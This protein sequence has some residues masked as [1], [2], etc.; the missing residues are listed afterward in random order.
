MRALT[1]AY[2]S[3]REVRNLE[4]MDIEPGKRFNVIHGDNG[5]GKTNTLEAMYIVCT[6]RS[7]RATRSSDVIRRGATQ[8]S[9][10][11]T[12]REEDAGRE[13]SV[14]L[15]GNLRTLRIDGAKPRSSA[16][17]ASRTPV[18]VFSPASLALTMGSS[19]ERRALLDRV[20]LY[21]DASTLEEVTSYTHALRTR[22][23]VLEE[24]GVR[25]RDLEDW[26][27]LVVRHGLGVMKARKGAADRL[28]EEARDVFERIGLTG[29]KLEG[30][31]RATAPQNEEAYRAELARSRPRDASRRSASIGPH[32]DDLVLEL[33][34]MPTRTTASQGQ[35][36]ALV[37]ALKAAEVRVIGRQR[38]VE[39][40]LLL[41]DVSSELDARRTT[42]FFGYLADQRGQIFLTTTRPE[43]L[44]LE[45]RVDFRIVSGRV[46]P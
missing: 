45:D 40:I 34:A 1:L 28:L 32:R 19:K 14:G 18:V 11:A 3:V 31:Y 35:H 7:F 29:T 26:E 13:Q 33:G 23:R 24:R 6:S 39:P 46:V 22:Q 44:A 25:A 12:I 4:A 36:R 38:G 30:D 20:G 5:Q 2:V 41:D 42:A 10:R 15:E 37:L 9:I 21:A 16:V 8:A 43:L 17:Y 27:A